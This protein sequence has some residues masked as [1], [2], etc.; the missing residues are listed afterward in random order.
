MSEDAPNVPG[1]QTAE[2]P[3]E[4]EQQAAPP[5]AQQAV[6]AGGFSQRFLALVG[7]RSH[8]RRSSLFARYGG[9]VLLVILVV[10]FSIV[11][12]DTFPTYSNLVGVISNQAITGIVAL[13][14]LMPLAAGAFDISIGGVM[15]LAVVLSTW[16]F[17]ATAGGM[18]IWASI[19]LTLVASVFAGA[20]NGFLVVVVKVDPFIATIG[21]SSVFLGI[22]EAVANGTTIA[23]HIPSGF[24][25]ISRL[26]IG[27]MPITVVYVL[28]LAGIIWYL[29]EAT[30]LGRR[31]YAT[32]A[33]RE[34]ARL[35][36]VRTSRI[37][38]WMFIASALVASLA[39]VLYAA[40]A[41]SGP[42][43]VGS[44]YLLPAY[45]SAFLGATMIRPGRFNVPGL[46]VAVMLVAVGING[47]QLLGISFWVVDLFQ[48]LALIVAVSLSRLRQDRA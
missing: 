10:V 13:G 28:I 9:V 40:N 26:T 7:N 37:I 20:F 11:L 19:L 43:N 14:I 33:N 35:A 12:P 42:P 27:R 46:L 18:P 23:A 48:G 21:S 29:L 17:Q 1:T 16:L 25:Q 32:G 2:A 34:A 3:P 30:P 39:G 45:S 36:G 31:V 5:D 8:G 44:G 4:G 6:P 47:L 24:T 22:S 38:F 15:T 41:G